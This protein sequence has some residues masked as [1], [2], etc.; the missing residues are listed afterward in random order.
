MKLTNLS[1]LVG[2]STG[3]AAADPDGELLS[4][5]VTLLSASPIISQGAA[6]DIAKMFAGLIVTLMSRW[7]FKLI[8]KKKE[9]KT[10]TTVEVAPAP[11]ENKNN[12]SP[13]KQNK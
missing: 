9:E 1:D 7:I 8:D 3:Y 12:S 11:E 5:V 2:L 13:E 10:Q 4:N 6:D